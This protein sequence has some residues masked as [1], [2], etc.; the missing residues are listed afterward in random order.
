MLGRK[1]GILQK[2]S[3]SASGGAQRGGRREA[4]DSDQ[5]NS[6]DGYG[7][8]SLRKKKKKGKGL[9]LRRPG[10]KGEKRRGREVG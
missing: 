5:E 1:E 4:V 9:S 8:S 6:A 3:I 7:N 2:A 10:E